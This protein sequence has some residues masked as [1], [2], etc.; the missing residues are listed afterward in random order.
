MVTIRRATL[1]DRSSVESVYATVV[2]SPF[3]LSDDEWRRWLGL[4]GIVVAEESNRVIGFGGID[5][6]ADEQLRWVYL[7]PEFQRS[8]IGSKI[9]HELETVAWTSGLRSI[10]LHATPGA[11]EFY[12]RSGYARIPDHEQFGHDHD[13]VEMVKQRPASHFT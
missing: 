9:L 10:R 2:G 3:L 13:G 11:I 7:L 12:S 5:V 1:L 8:G 4:D 6:T